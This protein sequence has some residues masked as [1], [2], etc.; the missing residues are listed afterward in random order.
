M[1]AGVLEFYLNLGTEVEGQADVVAAALDLIDD[2]NAARGPVQ[3]HRTTVHDRR[4]ERGVTVV[5]GGPPDKVAVVD[6]LDLAR[7]RM[8]HPHERAA[9]TRLVLPAELGGV[10][11]DRRPEV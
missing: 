10:V 4:I 8:P 11:R 9:L 3:Q 7:P 6:D 1:A 5:L 2:V